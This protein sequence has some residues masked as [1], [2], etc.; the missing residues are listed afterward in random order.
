[1]DLG[2]FFVY[3]K[4]ADRRNRYVL[5][6]AYARKFAFFDNYGSG[7]DYIRCKAQYVF[8]KEVDIPEDILENQSNGLWFCALSFRAARSRGGI[9]VIDRAVFH[10]EE[11]SDIVLFQLLY[12]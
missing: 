5:P 10:F 1:M 7:A 8:P 2:E 4:F 9:L 6:S 3:P 11:P 12:A